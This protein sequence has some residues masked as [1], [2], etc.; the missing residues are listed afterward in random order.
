MNREQRRRERKTQPE[1]AAGDLTAEI[2]AMFPTSGDVR[3]ICECGQTFKEGG[4]AI[5][6][7]F[8]GH[9][10]VR[11]RFSIGDWYYHD[12]LN[13]RSVAEMIWNRLKADGEDPQAF[14]ERIKGIVAER[15]TEMQAIEAAER[16]M[17]IVR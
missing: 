7:T 6:H 14:L 3:F 11:E 12:T 8:E 10:V 15:E 13:G 16:E 4:V 2:R 9:E 1:R 17:G 5:M